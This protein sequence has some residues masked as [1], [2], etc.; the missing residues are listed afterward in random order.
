MS[1]VW[2]Y[3]KD[4]LLEVFETEPEA[5]LWLALNDP[6]SVV[7]EQS[8]S[9]LRPVGSADRHGIRR[10]TQTAKAASGEIGCDGHRAGTTNRVAR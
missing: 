10:A 2:I 3:E 1:T 8:V 5:R 4:N 9:L 7:T 6:T